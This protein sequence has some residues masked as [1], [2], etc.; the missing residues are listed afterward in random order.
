ML[1]STDDRILDDRPTEGDVRR[2]VSAGDG[3]LVT[4]ERSAARDAERSL[5][6]WAR[7]DG[8]VRVRE[9]AVPPAPA[10]APSRHIYLLVRDRAGSRWI[11]LQAFDVQNVCVEG[12]REG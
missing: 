2:A 6:R 9:A 12:K 11:T 1:T 8:Y 3:V 5:R 4:L 7:S 10:G